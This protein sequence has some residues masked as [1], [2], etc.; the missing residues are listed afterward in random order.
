M[1]VVNR[2]S[3]LLREGVEWL[4]GMGIPNPRLEAEVLLSHTLG[5]DR[6]GLYMDPNRSIGRREIEI[7]KGF[8][9]ERCMRV[10]LPYITGRREFWSLDFEVGSGVLIPR[11]ETEVL[12]E[13]ALRLLPE[14]RPLRLIEVGTGCGVI[15][16]VLALELER[17][18]VWATD[19]SASALWYA[20]RNASAHKVLDRVALLQGRNLEPFKPI[21]AFDA[22]LSNPPY[23]PTREIAHLEPEIRDYE[24]LEALDGGV[25]GLEVIRR[26]IDEAPC[27]LKEGGWLILEVGAGQSGSV[28]EL[29][30]RDGRYT[31]PSF[32]RDYSGIERVVAVQRL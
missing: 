3:S 14:D 21:Q 32:R 25:D 13:E 23:I 20:R 2:V 8:I 29:L 9:R 4:N 27:Y 17:A 22:I 30:Q 7:Y 24:P 5:I 19:I 10:P 11:Q 15:S 12:V 26:I 1:Q 28:T 16:I 18:R 31:A 6:V